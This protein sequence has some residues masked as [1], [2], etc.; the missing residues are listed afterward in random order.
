MKRV[1]YNNS[2][3]S[4][5]HPPVYKGPIWSE[6]STH[7]NQVWKNLNQFIVLIDNGSSYVRRE[8]MQVDLLS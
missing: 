4:R 1:M 8:E 7:I 6:F 5:D 3:H 2:E